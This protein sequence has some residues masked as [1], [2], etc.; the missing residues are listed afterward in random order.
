MD[1]FTAIQ[2]RASVREFDGGAVSRADLTRI[3]DAARRAP[4][5]FTVQ[6]W[7][8]IAVTSRETLTALG[9]VQDCVADASAAVVAVGDPGASEFWREDVSAAV[10]NM[11]LACTALDHGSLWVAVLPE[12]ETLVRETLKIPAKLQPL[13]ILAIG[14]P[15]APVAQ[16]ERKP[17]SANCHD[18]TYGHAWA[19]TAD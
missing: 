3:L 8:F 19:D 16:A 11:H 14:R 6:P 2:T 10:E 9:R 18:E 4:T 15:T 13:A 5:A 1:L 12:K 7:H 17:L